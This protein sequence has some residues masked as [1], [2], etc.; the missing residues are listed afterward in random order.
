VFS[1]NRSRTRSHA[2]ALARAE[3]EYA[4]LSP[5]PKDYKAFLEHAE[6]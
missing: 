2:H 6:R 3:K 4:A 1:G 5:T